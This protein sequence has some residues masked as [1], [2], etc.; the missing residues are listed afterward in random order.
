[1]QVSRVIG[2]WG[3]MGLAAL[4]VVV[5][6]AV[7][8]LRVM[9]WQLHDLPLNRWTTLLGL[10]ADAEGRAGTLSIRLQ[11][12]T[13]IVEAQALTLNDQRE[14]RPVVSLPST[15]V[16]IDLLDVA[17]GRLPLRYLSLSAPEIHLYQNASGGWGLFDTPDDDDTSTFSFNDIDKVVAQLRY[18]RGDVQ[19]A[20]VFLHGTSANET[21][22]VPVISAQPL[23]NGAHQLAL[24]IQRE[25]STGHGVQAVMVYPEAVSS[26]VQLM[27]Q[28]DAQD[29]ASV[30]ALFGDQKHY[31]F[32]ANGEV[33]ATL[34]W[35]NA[36]PVDTRVSVNLPHFTVTREDEV[37]RRWSVGALAFTAG[38]QWHDEQWQGGINNLSLQAF[39][40]GAVRP[41]LLPTHA[42][43]QGDEER[44][45]LLLP[46]FD[47]RDTHLLWP[48]LPLSAHMRHMLNELAPTGHVDGA[49]ITFDHGKPSI[50]AAVHRVRIQPWDA[51]PGVGPLDGWVDTTL[52]RGTFDFKVGDQPLGLTLPEVFTTP[53]WFEQGQGRLTWT[54]DEHNDWRLLGRPLTL[55]RQGAA[56]DAQLDVFIPDRGRG[57]LSLALGMTHAELKHAS[58]WVPLKVLPA[59]LGQWL[60][61]NVHSAQVPDGRLKLDVGF[62]EPLATEPEESPLHVDLDLGVSHGVMSYLPDWPRLTDVSGRLRYQDHV[63]DADL[64][65]VYTQGLRGQGGHVRFEGE[66]L[67]VQSPVNGKADALLRFLKR[68]PLSPALKEVLAL[69]EVNGA[70]N[71]QLAMTIPFDDANT[72]MS[73]SADARWSPGAFTL[74]PDLHVFHATTQAR[75]TM[76]NN[77]TRLTGSTRGQAFG[78]EAA[79]QFAFEDQNGHVDI[80]GHA[81]VHDVLSWLAFKGLSPQTNGKAPY[82][83]RLDV[84]DTTTLRV[85]SSLS[86]IEIPLPAPLGKTK[87]AAAPLHVDMDL[88]HGQGQARVEHRLWA[89]WRDQMTQGQLWVEHWPDIRQPWDDHPGWTVHWTTPRISINEWSPVI[90]ALDMTAVGHPPTA[91]T[92]NDPPAVRALYVDTPCLALSDVCLGHVRL[93]GTASEQGRWGINAWGDLLA[94]HLNWLPGAKDGL[95][96]HLTRVDLDRFRPLLRQNAATPDEPGLY[97]E[98][99]TVPTPHVTPWP[100]PDALESIPAGE[101]VIDTLLFDGQPSGDLLARWH[102]QPDRLSLDQGR[103]RFKGS[104]L[105]L[106]GSW[107]RAGKASVTQGEAVLDHADLGVLLQAFDQPDVIRTPNGGKI[108]L[109][110]AWPGAPWQA[111]LGTTTGALD[112]DIK[113]GRFTVIDSPS[114]RLIGL[115]NV[116]NLLRRL[117]LDFTDVTRSGSAFN[118]IQGSATLSDGVLITRRPIEID[119]T[120]TH[121]SLDG[122]VDLM[123]RT[124][125]QRLGVT[126]PLL[127]GGAV[128]TVLAGF[129]VVGAVMLGAN[130]ALGDWLT[131]M[132]ELHY[133]IEGPWS[134]P[135]F[136]MEPARQ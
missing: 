27:A 4:S 49:R 99:L 74:L 3:L 67:S 14:Q 66:T 18:L 12:H 38:V 75:F 72:P 76:T 34:D 23:D 91:E 92:A 22:N 20:R 31:W 112:V 6:V 63:F 29:L 57:L 84:G 28:A 68:V 77:V 2:R 111:S 13:L 59:S 124:L 93:Q 126:L 32:Q 81:D 51:I 24:E 96:I 86:G 1:M 46:T 9:P 62:G 107:L 7:T 35:Q 70:L 42:R 98:V 120:T 79:A 45:D 103:F 102:V 64:A 15:Q 60:N 17:R 136:S 130:W 135:T 104:T 11:G 94:G 97:N 134:A 121:L 88:T 95:D 54:R 101:L 41:S 132:T 131:K 123:Q 109:R 128:V 133:R 44:L 61:D 110:Y 114:A 5:A 21:L 71:G 80:Q 117:R 119:A 129:P 125:N 127:Q 36:H 33:R 53:W 19:N 55:T 16:D 106:K 37:P 43:F 82:Q 78:G 26:P 85:D 40:N 56:L 8:S 52:D 118:S 50:A 73:L 10:P 116:N 87:E 48:L 108:N 65:E 113:S 100:L 105:A 115:L 90:S 47:V 122:Q 39:E 58:D 89:R 69:W 25:G 30:G 83:A